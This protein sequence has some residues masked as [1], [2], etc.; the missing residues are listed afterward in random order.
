MLD[1]I[2]AGATRCR[3]IFGVAE[4]EQA[5]LMHQLRRPL[6]GLLI[7][8][9]VGRQH[10]EVRL[11]GDPLFELF[12][13]LLARH[14][15]RQRKTIGVAEIARRARGGLLRRAHGLE[16][17]AVGAPG[18]EY[19]NTGDAVIQ[20]QFTAKGPA[21]GVAVD[22]SRYDE[23]AGGIDDIRVG[24]IIRSFATHRGEL[25]IVDDDHRIR[26]SRSAGTVD[27]RGAGYYCWGALLGKAILGQQR[28]SN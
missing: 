5:G 15:R 3:R 11:L 22:Q 17:V 19:E 12:A 27:Q 26:D 23:L 16:S 28:D 20:I 9:I 2:L 21:M 8:L 25:A 4:D 10:G 7:A 6:V 14:I 1:A 18:V 13:Y 24:G